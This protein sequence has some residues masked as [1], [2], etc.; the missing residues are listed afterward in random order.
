M[1][2][3]TRG[4]TLAT[5]QTRNWTKEQWDANYI[6]EGLRIFANFTVADQGRGRTLI[7]V[8]PLELPNH[9][10]VANL[11]AAAPEL[12]EAAEWVERYV[13][14][15]KRRGLCEIPDLAVDALVAAIAKTKE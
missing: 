10:A 4:R 6:G 13:S 8:V 12:L 3:W 1:E 5:N 14:D 11:I 15:M 9:D 7:A 2:Q